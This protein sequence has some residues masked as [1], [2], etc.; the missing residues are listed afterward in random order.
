MLEHQ[1]TN[2]RT[3]LSHSIDIDEAIEALFIAVG[4]A[5]DWGGQ[6]SDEELET[7]GLIVMDFQPQTQEWAAAKAEI[8]QAIEEALLEYETV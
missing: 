1:L 2:L 4:R 6:L 8:L 5:R 3:I 7:L